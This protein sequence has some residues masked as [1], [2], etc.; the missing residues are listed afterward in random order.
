MS[1]L[2]L[3]FFLILLA[4]SVVFRDPF[5]ITL[6][7]IFAGVLIFGRFWNDRALRSLAFIRRFP[8]RAFHGEKIPVEL[9]IRNRGR[10]PIV[11][12]RIT[13]GVQIELAATTSIRRIISLPGRSSIRIAYDLHARKRGR[14]PVGPLTIASADIFGLGSE[15][16]RR[17]HPDYVTVYPKILPLS[18]FTLPAMIPLGT[19]AFH[20]PFFEDP[21]RAVGDRDGGEVRQ[22][23]GRDGQRVRG[24]RAEPAV[25]AAA[26]GAVSSGQR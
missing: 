1:D 14:Y 8:P 16:D 4:T 22:H 20:Q 18:P 12:A 3:P 13:E 25:R 11:W 9:E 19:T 15:S 26:T 10:L 17:A 5:I 21:S 24:G 2:F 23:H 6:L 7:Y